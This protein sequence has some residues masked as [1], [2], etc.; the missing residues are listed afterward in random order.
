MQDA[1]ESGGGAHMRRISR[2][3]RDGFCRCAEEQRIQFFLIAADQGIQLAWAGE[4]QMI[5]VNV[6]YMF[7]L[8]VDPKLIGERLGLSTLI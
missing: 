7:V 5:I 8:R 3:L 2:K 6:Q 1:D 4:Y